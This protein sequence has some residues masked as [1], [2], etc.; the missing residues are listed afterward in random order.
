MALRE[1]M[2]FR[3]LL[4]D[5]SEQLCQQDLL[6]ICFLCSIPHRTQTSLD[7]FNYLIDRGEFSHTNVEPL[8]NLLKDVKRHDLVH[9]L[10]EPY[11]KEHPGSEKPYSSLTCSEPPPVR[12]EHV[13]KQLLLKLSHRMNQDDAQK[14]SYLTD[15]G[16]TGTATPLE[17]LIELQKQGVFSPRSCANLEG[18]LSKI[19]RCDLADIVRQYMDAYPVTEPSPL[20]KRES[21]FV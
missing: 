6:S 12:R 2:L 19:N 4:V 5:L 3:K 7:I 9:N 10:V 11:K 1:T 13:F 15:S 17:I 20:G 21:S 18:H 8:V 16:L 14:L